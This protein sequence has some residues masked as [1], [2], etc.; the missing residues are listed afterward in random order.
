VLVQGTPA[1][2]AIAASGGF[3]GQLPKDMVL[4]SWTYLYVGGTPDHTLAGERGPRHRRLQ[5]DCYAYDQAGTIT[6]AS[7][8]DVVLNN[9]RGTLSDPDST[10]VQ[11]CLME[12]EPMDFPYDDASRTFRRMIEYEIWF[13]Q[14]N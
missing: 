9:F 6:L 3:L 10:F 8:I 5:I 4:P 11:S 1:V 12:Q 2:A 14:A 13:N 7:A